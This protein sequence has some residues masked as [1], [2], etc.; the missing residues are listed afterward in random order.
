MNIKKNQKLEEFNTNK[1]LIV[2]VLVFIGIFGAMY[3]HRFTDNA[4]TFMVAYKFTTYATYVTSALALLFGL[5]WI[6]DVNKKKNTNYQYFCAKNLFF[7]CF[8]AAICF[9]MA[10][11]TSIFV[12]VK[13]IYIFLSAVA[14]SYFV[15][16]SLPRDIYFATISNIVNLVLMY[17][18]AQ[19]SNGVYVNL[20][21]VMLTIS[22]LFSVILVRIIEKNNGSLLGLKIIKNGGNTKFLRLN[23]ICLILI[24][25]STISI[26]KFNIPYLSN[27]AFGL[28]AS[29]IYVVFAIFAGILNAN[30]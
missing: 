8:T 4:A 9:L 11:F 10:Y 23:N 14:A 6:L 5:K 27:I 12:A 20:I 21:A 26:I 29:I 30:K 15:L 1:L 2:F 17:A 7:V 19:V 24:I 3:L 13:Y 25:I 16:V 22:V 28:F 18:L